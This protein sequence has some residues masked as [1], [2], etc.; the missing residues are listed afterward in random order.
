MRRR[1]GL[2][3]DSSMKKNDSFTLAG[4]YRGVFEILT[5][6]ASII[7]V[8]SLISS[9]FKVGLVGIVL[10][11]VKQYSKFRDALFVPLALLLKPLAITIP[12]YVKDLFVIYM[13]FASAMYYTGA[14]RYRQDILSYSKDPDGFE[15]KV[16]EGACSAGR[17]EDEV[18]KT[19]FTGINSRLQFFSVRNVI[20]SL[21]WPQK[22]YINLKRTR[23]G[24]NFETEQTRI[25]VTRLITVAIGTGIFFLWNYASSL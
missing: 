3:S 2:D 24:D 9:L 4:T 14:S 7:S 15:K 18:W 8:T 1:K 17:N 20:S 22:L 25:F 13:I 23:K 21:Y 10:D 5:S 16:R 12:F 6:L 19:V 11:V